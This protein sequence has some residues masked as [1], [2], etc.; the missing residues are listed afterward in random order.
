MDKIFRRLTKKRSGTYVQTFDFTTFDIIFKQTPKGQELSN[1]QKLLKWS[2][3]AF[4]SGLPDGIED[5]ESCS[6]ALTPAFK[7]IEEIKGE[8][9]PFKQL[10]EGV[11]YKGHSNGQHYLVLNKLLDIDSKAVA[12]EL[13]LWIEAD[14]SPN[15]KAWAGSVDLIRVVNQTIQVCDFK[16]DAGKVD[17]KK[18]A[19]QLGRYGYMLSSRCKIPKEDID[20]IFFDEHKAFKVLI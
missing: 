5:Y 15:Q 14:I 7:L 11:E 17:Q 16:P 1:F 6:S 2:R 13:P 9:N 20:L 19:A 10:L 4:I 8:A 12:I 18:V 3:Y